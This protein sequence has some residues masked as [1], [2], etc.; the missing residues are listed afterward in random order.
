[1]CDT[2]SIAVACDD[3]GN[4]K[5]LECKVD[6]DSTEVAQLYDVAFEGERFTSVDIS[7]NARRIVV[8]GEGG[9]ARVLNTNMVTEGV[10]KQGASTQ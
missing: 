7:G 9:V 1:V 8:V 6:E 5:L 2:G 3:A 10:W 4:V